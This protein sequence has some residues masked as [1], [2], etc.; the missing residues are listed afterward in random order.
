[1]PL[2]DSLYQGDPHTHALLAAYLRVLRVAS[3]DEFKLDTGD[4]CEV[5]AKN[6][7][8]RRAIGWTERH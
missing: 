6:M 8:S 3:S 5:V 7:E 4:I 1:M 2:R